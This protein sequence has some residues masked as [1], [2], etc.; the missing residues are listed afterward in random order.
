MAGAQRAADDVMD[1]RRILD[2]P[3]MLALEAPK[4]EFGDRR[5]PVLSNHVKRL[6]GSIRG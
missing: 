6:M 1:P 2:D 4:P 5:R 3:L